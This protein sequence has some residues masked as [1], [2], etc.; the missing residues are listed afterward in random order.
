V[1]NF[2]GLNVLVGFDAHKSSE[3]EAGRKGNARYTSAG[4]VSC[5]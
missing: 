3:H 1:K 4:L 2:V 5:W